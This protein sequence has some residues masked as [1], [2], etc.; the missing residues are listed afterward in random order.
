M[1]FLD[2][3]KAVL[4]TGEFWAALIGLA[5]VILHIVKPDMPPELW[6][7]IVAVLATVLAALG[8]NVA[9]QKA[10]Y[11]REQREWEAMAREELAEKLGG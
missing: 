10:N 11:Y 9:R 2:A 6:T 8:I 1:T 7:A 3:V 5:G 4:S